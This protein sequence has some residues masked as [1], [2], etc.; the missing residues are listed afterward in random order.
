MYRCFLKCLLIA[1]A[2]INISH[3]G[4]NK[5]TRSAQNHPMQVNKSYDQHKAAPHHHVEISKDYM[6]TGVSYKD[7]ARFYPNLVFAQSIDI[8]ASGSSQYTEKQFE[9]I[10]RSIVDNNNWQNDIVVVADLRGEGHLFAK[11]KFNDQPIASEPLIIADNKNLEIESDQ[12][13]DMIRDL[14][15][16][17]IKV[18]PHRFSTALERIYSN[19]FEPQKPYQLTIRKETL[20][21]EKDMVLRVGKNIIVPAKDNLYQQKKGVDVRYLRIPVPDLSVPLMEHVDRFIA[22]I[23]QIEKDNPGKKVW[24]HMHCHGGLGRTAFFVYTSYILRT[25]WSLEKTDEEVGKSGR[26]RLLDIEH[27][28]IGQSLDAA[29]GVRDMIITV[30]LRRHPERASEF[31][32]ST[33]ISPTELKTILT[34]LNMDTTAVDITPLD[35]EKFGFRIF[36]KT[37]N[38]S[39]Y[40]TSKNRLY[41]GGRRQQQ[42]DQS[43][44]TPKKHQQSNGR[45]YQQNW[46]NRDNDGGYRLNQIDNQN[47][48]HQQFQNGRQTPK[49]SRKRNRATHGRKQGN[50]QS[51]QQFQQIA[52][53]QRQNSNWGNDDDGYGLNSLYGV[54]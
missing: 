17:T 7:S 48:D 12:E 8:A 25:D 34:K 36:K 4:K 16:E 37:A 10:L 33:I 5:K 43:Q 51:S 20:E 13:Q 18:S 11:N 50:E 14:Q 38:T 22:G 39:T 31:I 44:H 2:T 27:P 53:K 32:N 3:A 41:E 26:R 52:K 15:G 9:Y 19:E 49:K 21:T 46:A 24:I 6:E 47:D 45:N 40:Y 42:Q 23:E 1:G 29:K 30:Y 35:I 54:Q 28:E